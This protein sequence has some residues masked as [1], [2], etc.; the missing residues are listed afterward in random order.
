MA[1]TRVRLKMEGIS[2]VLRSAPVQAAVAEAA[3]KGAA[4]AGEGFEAVV[5]PHPFTARAFVQTSSAEGRLREAREKVLVRV[6]GA[7]R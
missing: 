6:L 7:M 1:V 2:K 5:K 4:A 3:Q